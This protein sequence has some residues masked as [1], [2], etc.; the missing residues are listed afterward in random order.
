MYPNKNI[1]IRNGYNVA[2]CILFNVKYNNG[3]LCR[4]RR[5]VSAVI[6]VSH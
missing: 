4:D 1:Y 6:G 3:A 5:N 2:V